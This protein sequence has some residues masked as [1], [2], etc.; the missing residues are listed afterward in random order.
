[1]D[2]RF[3]YNSPKPELDFDE[4]RNKSKAPQWSVTKIGEN[5]PRHSAKRL[6]KVVENALFFSVT[7][8]MRPFGHLI[9]QR[10][11]PFFEITD[12]K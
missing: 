11:R 3:I 1:M 5:Y 6:Q 9:L 4:M 10:F 7:K 2:G 12:V 8:T